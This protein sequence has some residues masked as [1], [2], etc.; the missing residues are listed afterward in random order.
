MIEN[1]TK[2]KVIMLPTGFK[3][4]SLKDRT[5]RVTSR[6]EYNGI[7]FYH[8]A[9]DPQPREVKPRSVD[10]CTRRMLQIL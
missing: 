7:W 9:I 8:V 3:D 6:K 5:G 10:N 2:V 1:G 4:R